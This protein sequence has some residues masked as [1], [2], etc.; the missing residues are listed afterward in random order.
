LSEESVGYYWL[1]HLMGNHLHLGIPPQELG[2]ETPS[3]IEI[4]RKTYFVAFSSIN[5]VSLIKPM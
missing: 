5:N 3:K 2:I 4:D 1:T